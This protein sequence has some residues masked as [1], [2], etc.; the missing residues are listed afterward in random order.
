M[1]RWMSPVSRVLLK[2]RAKLWGLHRWSHFFFR[3]TTA[4]LI[5][6]KA[7]EE[8]LE[9]VLG[10]CG[11]S[12]SIDQCSCRRFAAQGHSYGRRTCCSYRCIHKVC[13]WLDFFLLNHKLTGD[14]FQRPENYSRLSDQYSEEEAIS[15]L[16]PH[17]RG[18]RRYCDMSG[19]FDARH[20]V[21]PSTTLFLL[22][23]IHLF[24]WLIQV[25]GQIQAYLNR[26][27]TKVMNEAILQIHAHILVCTLHFTTHLN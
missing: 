4:L 16:V 23:L 8:Q 13:V 20:G 2:L 14:I 27:E 3:P 6:N 22:W 17:R 10:H 21:V 26:S 7:N 12:M 9:I 24:N 5:L 19:H 1:E 18:C 11:A 15:T 25:K